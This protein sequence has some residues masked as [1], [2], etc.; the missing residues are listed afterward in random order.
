[1]QNGERILPVSVERTDYVEMWRPQYHYSTLDSRVN[2]PNGLVYYKGVYHL[3]YQCI[4]HTVVSENPRTS[5]YLARYRESGTDKPLQGQHWGHA[6]ST[7]LIHW[8]EQELALFPDDLGFMW[9]GTGAIDTNNT[10]GFFS[11]TED[12]QGI[13]IAYSTNTQHV[14]IAYSKDGGKSFVKVSETEPVLKNPGIG[15]FRDPHLFWH[16]ESACWKLVIAGKGGALWIYES[17]NLTD[18]SFCSVDRVVNTECPNLFKMRVDGLQETKW[19]LSCVGRGY[20]VG[21]F[22]GRVFTPETGYLTM[23]E[24]PDAYAGITFSGMPDGRT[25]MI[26]WLNAYDTVA[27]GVW[28][29]CFTVPVEMKLIR[30][31]NGYR[32]LQT[33]VSEFSLVLGKRLLEVTDRRVGKSEDLLQGVRSNRFVLDLVVDLAKSEAF[34]LAVCRGIGEETVIAYDPMNGCVSVDRSKCRYGLKAFSEGASHFSFFVDPESAPD[35]M[36]RLK[37][38]VDVSNLEL[39][40]NDGWYYFVMRM[41]PFTTSRGMSLQAKGSMLVKRGMVDE[42]RSIRGEEALPLEAVHLGDDTP[43]SLAV[44]E[45]SEEI[46]VGTFGGATVRCSSTDERIAIGRIENG[47]VRVRGVS[48]GEAI[49]LL[50]AGR[51]SRTLRV[52]VKR[53]AEK[54]EAR[55]LPLPPFQRLSEIA[56][57]VTDHRGGIS[58]QKLG[59]GRPFTVTDEPIG[60]FEAFAKITLLGAGV[61]EL[62]FGIENARSYRGVFLD[63]ARGGIGLFRMTEGAREELAFY[64]TTL[65]INQAHALRILLTENAVRITLNQREPLEYQGIFCCTGLLGFNASVCDVT[66]DGFCVEPL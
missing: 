41:Q 63:A 10:S 50:Y 48:D 32:L 45:E 7:D 43:L 16:T 18:W 4:P 6:T 39:F 61:A 55:P 13:V 21:S 8:Q 5:S 28:N 23:N 11:D 15:A 59:S 66:V 56:R 44:G 42:C 40:V 52:S 17:K 47:G 46:L 27:D 65:P 30:T 58:I 36:L 64:K 33:P 37:L 49:L 2:D 3:Y 31:K 57:A 53:E 34:S 35:R 54:M 26:S 1:M 12:R 14:G 24:G 51:F 38:L 29:G 9:S 25:V 62:L 19:I 20:Y 22:D 60:D